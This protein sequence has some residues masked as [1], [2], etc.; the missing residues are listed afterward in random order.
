MIVPSWTM[1]RVSFR[2]LSKGGG[3]TGG[4]WILGGGGGR[5]HDG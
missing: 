4:I 1:I 2:K 3:A 5:R